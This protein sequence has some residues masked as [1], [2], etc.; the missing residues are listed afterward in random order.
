MRAHVPTQSEDGVEV[1]LHH[2]GKV[3]VGKQVGR[4][5]TLDAGAVDQDADGVPIGEDAWH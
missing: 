4:V 5:S 3:G 2:F 1:D